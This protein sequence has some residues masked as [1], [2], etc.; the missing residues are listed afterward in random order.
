MYL[1]CQPKGGFTDQLC[2]ISLC[3]NYAIKNG[4]ILLLDTTQT[5]YEYNFDEYF[6][7]EDNNNRIITDINKIRPILSNSSYTIYPEFLKSC[8]DLKTTY[9]NRRFVEL[10]TK[11][12]LNPDLN[13]KY[14]QNILV[15]V[16]CGGC[17]IS[18]SSLF[19][20]L[21]PKQPLIDYFKNNYELIPK[22]YLTV[23]IRNTDYKCDYQKFYY[24]NEDL[25]KSYKAIFI[26]TDDLSSLNFFKSKLGEDVIHNFTNFPTEA[27]GNLHDS[28]LSGETKLKDMFSDLLIAS[29]GDKVLSQSRGGYIKFIQSLHNNKRLVEKMINN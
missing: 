25:L 26:A 13:R 29:L 17:D 19:S 10:E 5:C 7:I 20:K 1:Y 23:H 18:K 4:R 14:Q 12:A 11:L 16:N 2:V 21:K 9:I 27:Y 22:P 3:Y 8:L 15:Y 28:N 6:Q 24:Q